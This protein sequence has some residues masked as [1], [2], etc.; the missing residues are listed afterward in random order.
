LGKGRA[1]RGNP[2]LLTKRHSFE[3][4]GFR[5]QFREWEKKEK[6][7]KKR[8]PNTPIKTRYIEP[9][10]K[11]RNLYKRTRAILLKGWA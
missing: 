2:R 8:R 4:R 9:F 7:A 3:R 5:P 10:V 6:E 1:K 11:L